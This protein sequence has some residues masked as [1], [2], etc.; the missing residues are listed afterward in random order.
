MVPNRVLYGATLPTVIGFMVDWSRSVTIG[1]IPIDQTRGLNLD[2]SRS[3]TTNR[4]N[5]GS[6]PRLVAISHDQSTI[7]VPLNFIGNPTDRDRSR[8]I[9]GGPIG[10]GEVAHLN[11]I[12]KKKI[13]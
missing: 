4:P 13:R 5:R 10:D 3:V 1:R 11:P 9:T 7:P 8:P 2:W 6:Q 12:P